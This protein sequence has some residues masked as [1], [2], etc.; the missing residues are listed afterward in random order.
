[1]ENNTELSPTR[2]RFHG[3]EQLFGD[4]YK[5]LIDAKV[6]VVGVGGVGSWAAEALVRSGVGCLTIIDPDD[7]CINN[8]NRQIQALT[9]SVGRS[10]VEVL[11][12]RFRTINPSCT[13]TTRQELL[14]Q[15]NVEE[16]LDAGDFDGVIDAIDQTFAKVELI[17]AC[18]QRD[19]PIVV[20]GSAGGVSNPNRVRVVDLNTTCN[21]PMLKKVRKTLRQRHGWARGTEDFGILCVYS[22]EKIKTPQTDGCRA[23]DPLF[24]RVSDSPTCENGLGTAVFVTGTMGFHAAS[25]IVRNITGASIDD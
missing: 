8:S 24:G 22:S 25:V 13:I 2:G 20:S 17:L 4:G 19:I 3:C 23:V 21:D 12:E 15:E 10:K 7:I 14:C 5:N 9:D 11:A 16:I 6:A 1:M 18:T